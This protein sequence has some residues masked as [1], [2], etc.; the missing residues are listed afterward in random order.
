MIDHDAYL[1]IRQVEIHNAN[2]ISSPITYGF[3]AVTGFLGAC[4]ALERKIPFEVN[5]DFCG[6][7][8]ACHECRIKRYRP[9]RYSDYTLNQSRNP[10]KKD[11]KTASIIEEGKTDLTVSFVIPLHYEDD[12]DEDWLTDNTDTFTDWVKKT[13]YCQPMAGGSVFS[14]GSVDIIQPENLDYLKASLAPAFVLMEAKKDLID[15]TETLQKTH[16]DATALDALLEV[17]MLHHIPERNVPEEKRPEKDKNSKTEWTVRNIK[18]G[19]GWLVPMPV[20]Y[21]S[22]SPLFDPGTMEE[23][24]TG[25]YPS[26]FVETL[27]GLGKWVFPYSLTSLSHA[28]WSMNTDDE[29]LYLIQQTEQ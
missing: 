12:D 10:I 22:I 26:Q 13:L 27:Y 15:I 2:G 24:R 6:V 28:F 18:Q 20:G 19:R 21:Q 29:G 5:L 7:L 1:Y 8:I 25:D 16:A 17:A 11:G 3:P 4:H 9:H 14:V 23:C